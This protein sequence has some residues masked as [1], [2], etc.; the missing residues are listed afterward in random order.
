MSDIAA[1]Y[2]G[3][4]GG[5]THVHWSAGGEGYRRTI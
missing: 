4:F 5:F 2:Q 1:L 3:A